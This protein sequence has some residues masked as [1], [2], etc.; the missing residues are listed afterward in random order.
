MVR[1]VVSMAQNA[2]VE[3]GRQI[4]ETFLI[5]NEII[6]YRQKKREK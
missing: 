2:F 3:E 6:D 1:E 4:T 5:T